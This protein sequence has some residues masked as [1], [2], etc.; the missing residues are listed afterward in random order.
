MFSGKCLNFFLKNFQFSSKILNLCGSSGF[1][2]CHVK[3]KKKHPQGKRQG[4]DKDLL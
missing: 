4:K 2:V 3:K 1:F